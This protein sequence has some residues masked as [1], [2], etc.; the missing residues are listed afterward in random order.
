M[1]KTIIKGIIVGRSDFNKIAGW[2]E[3]CRNTIGIKM[4]NFKQA[5]ESIPENILFC[6]DISI[7]Q[8]MPLEKIGEEEKSF[9]SWFYAI[10]LPI[11]EDLYQS[12]P[13]IQLEEATKLSAIDWETLYKKVPKLSTLFQEC[14]IP[15][16]EDA[17]NIFA[18]LI[19]RIY[20]IEITS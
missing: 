7:P 9:L 6:I 11:V 12:N 18:I 19:D 10:I 13:W 3:D 1:R 8:T 14:R 5:K 2:I 4:L 20:E 16:P 15:R 17:E